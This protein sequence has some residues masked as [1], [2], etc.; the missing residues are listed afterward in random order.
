MAKF[1]FSP[2]LTFEA[3]QF[4]NQ[5]AQCIHNIHTMLKLAGIEHTWWGSFHPRD[6]T[7][8]ITIISLWVS[9]G[10]RRQPEYTEP[11]VQDGWYVGVLNGKPL[12]IEPDVFEALAKPFTVKPEHP[13]Q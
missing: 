10:G 12:L 9:P 1:K 5:D 6:K 13:A 11:N 8:D 4:N 3:Y 7:V 2:S